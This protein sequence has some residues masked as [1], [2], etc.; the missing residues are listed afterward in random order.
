MEHDASLSARTDLPVVPV[1]L[2]GRDVGLGLGASM[3]GTNAS[4]GTIFDRFEFI[5]QR[6]TND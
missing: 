5:E 3:A 1:Q 4:N 6:D 2:S